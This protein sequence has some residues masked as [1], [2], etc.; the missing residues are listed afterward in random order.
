[1]GN[2]PEYNDFM[3]KIDELERERKELLDWYKKKVEMISARKTKSK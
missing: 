2:V 3:Q 1:L